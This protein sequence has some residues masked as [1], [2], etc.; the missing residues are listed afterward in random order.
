ME[1]CSEA[2]FHLKICFLASTVQGPSLVMFLART[3]MERK[4]LKTGA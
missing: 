2:V 3:I 1:C 4:C